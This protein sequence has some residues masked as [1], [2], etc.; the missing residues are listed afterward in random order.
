MKN[1]KNIVITG[2][3]SGLGAALAEFYA[4][5]GI[6]LH[7]QGRNRQRLEE[8]AAACRSKGA[9]VH[10][11]LCDVTDAEATKN[12]LEKSDKISPID[13]VIA[14]A[15][16]SAG[17][18]IHGEGE[19]QLRGIFAVNIDGVVNTVEP[20]LP[21][22][23]ARRRGQ[24]AVMSSLAGF[25]G[26][27]SC[28]AYSASKMCVRA[29]GEAWRGLYAAQ[30]VEVSV[31]CPGYVKTPMTADNDFPMPFMMNADKAAGIIAKGLAKNK[32]RIVFPFALY[33]P[34]WLLS[35]LS[36][37]L[38]DWLFSRLPGKASAS[39]SGLRRIPPSRRE[40]D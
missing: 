20:L 9:A 31:I 17:T 27:P 12:W 7:L 3:S 8:T 23:T 39:P 16:I 15:G 6:T 32:T 19:A 18:G 26:L 13:L 28:P 10:G 38:T 22:M 2:A 5:T 34:L 4:S 24:I 29:L 37:A 21:R 1:P 36:P 30:G 11:E 33:F 40:R 14:N 35:C 25:R